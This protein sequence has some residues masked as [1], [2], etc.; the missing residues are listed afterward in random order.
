MYT[1]TSSSDL[2]CKYPLCLLLCLQRCNGQVNAVYFQCTYVNYFSFTPFLLLKLVDFGFK[3]EKTK[4]HR[5]IIISVSLN[6]HN[7]K[8]RSVL[9]QA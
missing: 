4:E 7:M 8:L 5:V 3:K 2:T 9:L 6:V 1:D